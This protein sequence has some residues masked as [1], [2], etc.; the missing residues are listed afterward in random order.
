MKRK[1]LFV[2]T[3]IIAIA[4]ILGGCQKKEAQVKL[5]GAAAALYFST[6]LPR[7]KFGTGRSVTFLVDRAGNYS[8]HRHRGLELNGLIPFRNH[9]LIHQ[10]NQLL[11]MDGNNNVRKFSYD[12]CEAPAGY[13]QSAGVLSDER[14]HYA[15]FNYRF[16]E[17]MDGYISQLRWGDDNRQFCRPIYE[18]MMATGDDGE[19]VYF[20]SSDHEDSRRMHL[21]RIAILGDEIGMEKSFLWQAEH[22]GIFF[23]TRLVPYGEHELAFIYAEPDGAFADLKL[24]LIDKNNPAVRRTWLLRRYDGST[25]KYYFFNEKSLHVLEDTIYYVDGYG[26]VFAFHPKE[27]RLEKKFRFLDYE[28]MA[29]LQDEIVHFAGDR[30]YFFR[31][32]TD[33]DRHVLE[34]YT[35]DGKRTWSLA[36]EGLDKHAGSLILYD[37]VML[38]P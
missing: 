27:N 9:L 34:Q 18:Y 25:T 30:L 29:R 24:A 4:G 13:G 33:S 19:F 16:A 26:S 10:K 20:I 7:E 11:V 17:S 28:R 15:L 14:W 36:V 22:D 31:K 1:H 32:F 38:D 6:P 12:H 3:F 23:F 8:V 35:L 37:F 21:H 5:S 2:W